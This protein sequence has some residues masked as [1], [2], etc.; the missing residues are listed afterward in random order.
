MAKWTRWFQLDGC[1]DA[2]GQ[3][4]HAFL[5]ALQHAA[6]QWDVGYAASWAIR[7]EEEHPCLLAVVTLSDPVR[8]VSLG[9]YGVHYRNERAR[10][11]L[12]HDCLHELPDEPTQLALDASGSPEHV[13]AECAAWF[14]AILRKPPALG[15]P[16]ST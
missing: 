2:L 8:R 3:D 5:A 9:Q 4:E 6:A 10:G 11:D 15:R 16:R 12:L 14:E 1:S 13:A 7:D